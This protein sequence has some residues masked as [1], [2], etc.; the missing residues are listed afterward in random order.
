METNSKISDVTVVKTPEILP[1]GQRK[2]YRFSFLGFFILLFTIPLSSVWYFT[3][4]PNPKNKSIIVEIPV[5]GSVRAIA[6]S[7]QNS[8][9]IRSPQIFIML[10][11][12]KHVDKKLPSGSFQFIMPMNIFAVMSQITMNERGIVQLKVTIPEGASNKQIAVIITKN[13]P[14]ITQDEFINFAKGREGYLFPDTYFFFITAT[15]GP[16]VASLSE[17]FTK[18]TDAL[19]AES[20]LQH[21][22]WGDIVIMA[23]LIEEEAA[24]NE[25]RKIISGILWNRIDRG[26]RLQVDASFAY[27]FGKQSS[28]I[29][30]NDLVYDSP[31]NMYRNKGLPPAPIT[32]PGIQSIDAALHPLKTDY[33][34]YLSDN[35]GVM[36]YA[37]TFEEHKLNKAK[38]LR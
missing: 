3:Q 22:E 6:R 8:G 20:L 27:L 35:K 32:N 2:K 25:D 26:M 9:V 11:K 18:R 10:A 30:Q 29:T 28:E 21:K 13:F 4:S 5:G 15:S 37:R 17:N 14:N 12:W 7:L 24:T 33:L 31:Y 19:R 36:H 16:I 34:Y 1:Q 23:S 38:Y